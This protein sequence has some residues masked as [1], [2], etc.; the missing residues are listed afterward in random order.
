MGNLMQNRA[1][2]LLD[3]LSGIRTAK[4][5]LKPSQ[6]DC[7][8]FAAGWVKACTGV[9]PASAWRGKYRSLDE[10]RAM[11]KGAGYRDLDGLA[12]AHLAE[13][14]GWGGSRPGDIAAVSEGG[15]TALGIIG[16]PQIHVLG[17]KGLDY[18]HLDRAE[19]VFRP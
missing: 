2:L 10:G 1:E 16:G 12:A 7:A 13:I 6:F 18:L 8:F 4:R 9:D 14:D 3:Y 17:L 11:L 19:R 15:H 5:V